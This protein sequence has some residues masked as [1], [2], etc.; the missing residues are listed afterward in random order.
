KGLD[1]LQ[2]PPVEILV[3]TTD[4]RGNGESDRTEGRPPGPRPVVREYILNFTRSVQ[5]DVAL[6]APEAPG[7]RHEV[8]GIAARDSLGGGHAAPELARAEPVR[9]GRHVRAGSEQDQAADAPVTGARRVIEHLVG[10]GGVS[11]Q[12]DSPVSALAGERDHGPDVL[13]ALREALE[14][15]AGELRAAAGDDAVAAGVEFEVPDAGGVEPRRELEGQRLRRREHRAEAVPP[16]ER[17]AA[18]T[19]RLRR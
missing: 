17:R 19:P 14:G 4:D 18:P 15:R 11:G 10:A 3:A 16:D 1:Q 12:N 9:L 6:G 5:A 7:S 2:R 8:A 13:D